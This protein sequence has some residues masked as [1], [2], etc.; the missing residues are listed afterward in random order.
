M[1]GVHGATRYG[2]TFLPDVLFARKRE[3]VED[4]IKE[5]ITQNRGG[6]PTTRDI[7]NERNN[8]AFITRRR[9]DSMTLSVGF[10]PVSNLYLALTPTRHNPFLR[11]TVEILIYVGDTFRVMAAWNVVVKF[12]AVRRLFQK[13]FMPTLMLYFR[14]V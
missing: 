13:E 5:R 2:L 14:Q 1:H 3:H 12:I 9:R 11:Q 10:Y 7:H 6:K 8:N 4:V